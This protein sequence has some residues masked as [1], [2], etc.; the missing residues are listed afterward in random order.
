[1]DV[2]IEVG[3]MYETSRG[4]TVFTQSTYLQ[5]Y[6]CVCNK[7]AVAVKM[8]LLFS[9]LTGISKHPELLFK[10]TIIQT[11]FNYG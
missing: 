10:N 9:A 1:M 5:L 2:E 11:T 6:F 3:N 4:T 8:A 7:G